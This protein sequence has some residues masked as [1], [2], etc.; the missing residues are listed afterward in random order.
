MDNSTSIII[1]AI[2]CIIIFFICRHLLCWY[3]KINDAIDQLQEINKK[4][5]TLIELQRNK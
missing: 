4:L 3:W 1:T 2:I 5:S